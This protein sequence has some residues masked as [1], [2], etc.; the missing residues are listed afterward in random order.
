MVVA[1]LL[2]VGVGA[3]LQLHFLF[4]QSQQRVSDH[5]TLIAQLARLDSLLADLS[6][7]QAAYVAPGQSDA[8]WLQRVSDLSAQ[9]TTSFAAV[10]ARTRSSESAPAIQSVFEA[11]SSLAAADQNAREHLAQDQ[12]LIAADI[13]FGEARGAIT[14]ARTAT[15]QI[16]TS[17][18][19]AFGVA[20][21]TS[22]QRALFIGGITA[23]IW[24]IGLLLLLPIRRPPK[25]DVPGL[26]E[27]TRVPVVTASAVEERTV[28]TPATLDLADA[29]DLCTALSRVVTAAALPDMLA[30][31]AALV[32]ASGIIVW[33]GS[34]NDLHAAIAHG[35][36]PRVIRQ[37]GSIPR[38]ADN[39]TAEAWRTGALRVVAGDMMSNGAIVAPMF[40]PEGCVGVLA[41]EVL[42]GREQDADTQA[43]TLIVAAQLATIVG[44]WPAAPQARAA[45]A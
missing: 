28:R 2:A 24:L 15:A 13:V 42:H 26:A 43:V 27:I 38:D 5:G 11:L 16:A 37:L 1:L 6:A 39:A 34:G 23:A 21:A 7:A 35:Y 19:A 12:D 44:A 17:E 45:E 40:G 29:A 32:D 31:T 18:I 20:Q 30:R 25:E 22:E 10:R 8:P 3:G 14:A 41:A 33:M 4:G 36:N 9:V